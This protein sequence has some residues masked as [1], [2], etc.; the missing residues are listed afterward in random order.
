MVDQF[1]M[2]ETTEPGQIELIYYSLPFN[3]G[4]TTSHPGGLEGYMREVGAELPDRLIDQ[5]R[6]RGA[7]LVNGQGSLSVRRRT[8]M[9]QYPT[10]K[11]G[12][13]LDVREYQLWVSAKF[14]MT[15]CI[16]EFREGGYHMPK[17]HTPNCSK[18]KGIELWDMPW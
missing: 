9:V 3:E 16:E 5:A 7:T 14:T 18:Y 11:D 1:A 10:D 17:H 8:R 4:M 15:Q 6:Q 2:Q 13:T 12:V